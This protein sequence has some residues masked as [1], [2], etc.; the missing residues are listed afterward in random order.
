MEPPTSLYSSPILSTPSRLLGLNVRPCLRSHDPPLCTVT[1]VIFLFLYDYGYLLCHWL[2]YCY[3]VLLFCNV[4]HVGRIDYFLPQDQQYQC[5][6]VEGTLSGTST[7]VC[8]IC[9][10][11]NYSWS[12]SKEFLPHVCYIS[13]PRNFWN[14][15]EDVCRMITV[16]NAKKLITRCVSAD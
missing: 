2:F 4:L 16:R 13:I 10:R 14:F 7:G 9:C 3:F 1:Y 6:K 11:A 8:L 12:Q 15:Q 5:D